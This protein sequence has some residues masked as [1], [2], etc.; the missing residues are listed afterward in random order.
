MA[1]L[2]I[3]FTEQVVNCFWGW[4]DASRYGLYDFAHRNTAPGFMAPDDQVEFR[5]RMFRLSQE[6]VGKFH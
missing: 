5:G 1:A 4:V 2:A 3:G 6:L